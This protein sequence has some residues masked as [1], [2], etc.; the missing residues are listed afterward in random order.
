VPAFV[1]QS[2]TTGTTRIVVLAVIRVDDGSF[3]IF[4]V[5]KVLEIVVL[6][7]VVVFAIC[8]II[9]V[10]IVIIIIR[11]VRSIRFI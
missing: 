11:F 4:L 5:K 3:Q 2:R 9:E 6:A 8:V 7:F 10:F 1:Q